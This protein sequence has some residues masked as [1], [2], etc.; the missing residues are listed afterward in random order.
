MKIMIDG[1]VDLHHIIH[2]LYGAV[3]TTIKNVIMTQV[4][5]SD[6]GKVL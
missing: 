4:S 2:V 5:V 3:M 1:F 6:S